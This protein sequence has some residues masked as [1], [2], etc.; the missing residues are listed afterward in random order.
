V[1]AGKLD[2]TARSEFRVEIGDEVGLVFASLP[3]LSHGGPF[4]LLI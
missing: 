2:R 3:M 4:S 1:G